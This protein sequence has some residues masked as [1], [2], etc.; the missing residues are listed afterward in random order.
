MTQ[1]RHT[2][3]WLS[4]IPRL[5]AGQLPG[6][7][8]FKGLWRWWPLLAA[9]VV[10][11]VVAGVLRLR[12]RT[13][14]AGSLQQVYTVQRGNLTATVS[15]TGEVYA[16]RRAD[17]SFDVSKVP[18][19]ELNVAA[20]QK[21]KAGD[22]L[23]RIDTTTLERAVTQAQADLTVAQDNLEK[24][25]NPYTALDL[26]KARLAVDQAQV[27]LAEAQENL[28]TLLK[29]DIAAAENAESD[30]AAALKS[31]QSQ[32]VAAQNDPEGAARLRTLEYEAKWYEQNYWEAQ[33]KF[34]RGEINQQKLD[35]EYSNM[36]AAQEKLRSARAKAEATLASAQN[37]VAKAQKAYQD[38]QNNLAKL[39]AGP[40]AT[41]LAK[42]KNQ[43]AQAQY[44]LDKAKED[45]ALIEAGPKARDIE[46][47]QAKVVSAQ[48]ALDNAKAALKAA[49]MTAP[50]DGTI[51]SVG[52]TV[53]DLVSSG[54]TVI[55]LADLTDLRVRAIVD[56]TDIGNVQV[57]QEATI[58][59]DAFPGI[60]FQGKVLEVP[61]QGK[62][63][64]NILTYEVPVS[65]GK[66]TD[67][68]LK[69]GMTANVSILVGRRQNVLLVPVLAVQQG[70]EG[71][72]VKVLDSPSGPA[73]ETR[74]VLGLSDGLNVEVKQGLNEGDRVVFEYQA[75][76]QSATGQRNQGQNRGQNL[77]PMMPPGGIGR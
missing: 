51:V 29:P 6:W 62:L 54:T 30:A 47:A 5:F 43:V 2:S 68:S 63:S 8:R 37:A 71:N 18:L 11:G 48:A 7:G 76:Q 12:Q 42:A 59:F 65:M 39:K 3:S 61:L 73:V 33:E 58:T 52:A 50:F 44:N 10:V 19:I 70:E 77:G 55:V 67:V 23:A 20:G 38:A 25:K 64:Q 69:P 14:Q 66:V 53:G 60:R 45:L 35:W 56:E 74:V 26:A 16:P 57:G 4:R 75:T 24:V 22:V 34:K 46:V 31:A 1:L 36:L 32:L 9:L 28:D 40:D 15:T 27:A 41:D 13:G 72:V 21:V 17:L 49:T